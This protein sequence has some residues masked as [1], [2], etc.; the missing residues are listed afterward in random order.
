MR[1]IW[2]SK[3]AKGRKRRRKKNSLFLRWNSPTLHWLHQ[4]IELP[5]SWKVNW[6]Y[7]CP[8][9]GQWDLYNQHQQNL[10][11]LQRAVPN[12]RRF[13]V[14]LGHQQIVFTGTT[15]PFSARPAVAIMQTDI[16]P[17]DFFARTVLLVGHTTVFNESNI[18]KCSFCQSSTL[19]FFHSQKGATMWFR[20]NSLFSRGISKCFANA[21]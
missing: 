19:Y 10:S 4:H 21:K 20:S 9:L 15:D 5:I 1:V 7:E 3:K 18:S 2:D 12:S 17:T 14:N 13:T 16:R 11:E 6:A 8:H